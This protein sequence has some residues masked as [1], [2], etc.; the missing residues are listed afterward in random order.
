MNGKPMIARV[1]AG[2]PSPRAAEGRDDPS[3]VLAELGACIRRLR[4]GKSWSRRVLA[5]AASVSERHLAQ[6]ENGKG[7]I[8][9]ALL[10]RIASALEA[11]LRDLLLHDGHN[12]V[13]QI[14]IEELVRG[15]PDEDRQLALQKLREWFPQGTGSRGRLALIGLRGAGK[16]TIGT[17][18]AARLN[19]PFIRLRNEIQRIAGMDVSEI[20]SLSGESH[21]RRLEERALKGTLRNFSRCV[22]ETGGSIVTEP[23]SFKLLLDS[24]FVVWIAASP[25]DHMQRVIDQADLR[26][27]ADNEDAM[28]DLRRILNQRRP[29]YMQAHATVHTSGKAVEACVTELVRAFSPGPDRPGPL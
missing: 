8:S 4:K 18:V 26:P 21:Y 19:L 14:L 5:E 7:N 6:L 13:E 24:C 22:I 29:C 16:T 2:A 11:N 23:G 28:S 12:S 1:A 27:M 20:F 3:R 9:V 10:A 25:E 15:L 17:E